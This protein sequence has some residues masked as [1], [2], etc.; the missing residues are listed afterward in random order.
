VF[1]AGAVAITDEDRKIVN[2]WFDGVNMS[3]R[4]NIPPNR[5]AMTSLWKWAD[6]SLT[7]LEVVDPGVPK[8]DP[9]MEA[10]ES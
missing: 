2:A 5:R 6:E 8:L 4:G 7:P 1:V 9:E 3:S 10:N